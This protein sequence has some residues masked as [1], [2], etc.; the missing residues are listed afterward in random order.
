MAFQHRVSE[1]LESNGEYVDAAG[2]APARTW[3]RYGGPRAAPVT[4]DV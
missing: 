2:L 1:L 4:T 3:V